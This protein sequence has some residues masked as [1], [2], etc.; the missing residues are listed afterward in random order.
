MYMNDLIYLMYEKDGFR[1]DYMRTSFSQ[2]NIYDVHDKKYA[3]H[4]MMRRS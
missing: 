3:M 2:R 4:V 1:D